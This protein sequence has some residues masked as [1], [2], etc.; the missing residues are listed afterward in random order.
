MSDKESNKKA[1]ERE[2]RQESG[3]FGKI[4]TDSG[5]LY[6]VNSTDPPHPSKKEKKRKKINKNI[7]SF[8]K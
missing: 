4:K 2:N 1:F 7:V 3:D 8:E 6:G 5:E